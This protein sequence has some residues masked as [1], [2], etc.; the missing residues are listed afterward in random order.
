MHEDDAALELARALAGEGTVR[1][2]PGEGKV[3]VVAG[4]AGILRVDHEALA[5]T[6]SL[7]STGTIPSTLLLFSIPTRSYRAPAAEVPF[8]PR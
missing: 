5:A 7:V 8:F 6:P 1:G 2:G 3:L 4:T